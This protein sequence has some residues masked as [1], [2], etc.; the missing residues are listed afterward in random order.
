MHGNAE[1]K[2]WDSLGACYIC[3]TFLLDLC[4]VCYVSW[5]FCPYGHEDIWVAGS[6]RLSALLLAQMSK[7]KSG[8]CYWKGFTDFSVCFAGDVSQND[9]QV[10]GIYL[11]LECFLSVVSNYTCLVQTSLQNSACS[12]WLIQEKICKRN[13]VMICSYINIASINHSFLAVNNILL[14]EESKGIN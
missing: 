2:Q 13:S 3:L 4:E 10:V 1:R 6:W 14:M 12:L 9:T 8:L 7:C 5:W 11:S